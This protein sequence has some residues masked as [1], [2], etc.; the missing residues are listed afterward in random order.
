M[1][2]VLELKTRIKNT[3]VTKLSLMTKFNMEGNFMKKKGF[4]LIELMVVIAII[5]LLAAIALPRFTGVSD[6]AKVA[7]VQGNLSG[8][9]TSIAMYQARNDAFPELED[10]TTQDYDLTQVNNTGSGID[11]DTDMFTTFWAQTVLPTTPADTGTTNV[12]ASNIVVTATAGTTN[13]LEGGTGVGGW[14]YRPGDGQIRANLGDGTE[15]DP[16]YSNDTNWNNF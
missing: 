10:A 6:S 3:I 12:T 4:T 9:R 8:L 14:L 1:L 11:T 15:D 7:Q 16:T 2:L 5:G 13:A